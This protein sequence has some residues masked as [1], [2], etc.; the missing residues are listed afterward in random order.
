MAQ[1][2]FII[3]F[4]LTW[5]LLLSLGLYYNISIELLIKNI[6]NKKFR[7]KL[8]KINNPLTKIH[9]LTKI[10]YFKKI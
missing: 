8:L 3:I 2:D 5:S 1:F 4:P 9:P 7:K 10:I 6:K